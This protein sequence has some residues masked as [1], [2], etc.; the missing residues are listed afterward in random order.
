MKSF[1]H[2]SIG[3]FH[4]VQ[5]SMRSLSCLKDE[6]MIW[7]ELPR[8][9]KQQCQRTKHQIEWNKRD[10]QWLRETCISKVQLLFVSFLH[11]P[12]LNE[13][14]QNR[15]SLEFPKKSTEYFWQPNLCG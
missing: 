5:I 14:I 6:R 1:V 10:W 15:K 12:P 8:F 2:N 4:H 13:R 3:C 11:H 9:P 7:K